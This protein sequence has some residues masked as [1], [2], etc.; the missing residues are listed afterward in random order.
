MANKFAK[1]GKP[2]RK[3]RDKCVGS[4]DAGLRDDHVTY[5]ERA[6]IKAQG[7]VRSELPM[8]NAIFQTEMSRLARRFT[9]A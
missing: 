9:K 8:I 7:R 2:Y 6:F 4:K 1:L 5:S 3:Q